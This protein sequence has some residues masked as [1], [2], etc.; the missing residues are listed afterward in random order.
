[1]TAKTLSYKDLDFEIRESARR[2]TLELIVDRDGS[3]VLAI[4]WV[5]VVT[6]IVSMVDRLL[7]LRH[8]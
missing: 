4:G 7:A 2:R 8:A 5:L 6:T 1:M 3:L